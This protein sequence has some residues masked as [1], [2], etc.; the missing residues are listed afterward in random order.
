MTHTTTTYK[1]GDRIQLT[2]DIHCMLTRHKTGEQGQVRN[3]APWGGLL[4]LRM[5]DGRPQ[6][7]HPDEITRVPA[8]P[9]PEFA[10]SHGNDSSTWTSADFEAEFVF[11]EN[12]MQDL[13]NRRTKKPNTDTTQTDLTPAA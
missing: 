1:V 10:R 12:D 6:F 4:R 13:R 2:T 3:V 7:A 5:D 8:T 9:G 11:A